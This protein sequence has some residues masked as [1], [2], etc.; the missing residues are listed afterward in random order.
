MTTLTEA[1]DGHFEVYAHGLVY[2]SVCTSLPDG[3]AT[4]RLNWYHPTGVNPWRIADDQTF[5]GG[6]SNPTQCPDRPD[7][8]HILFSC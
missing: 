6:E 8:R 2:A 4:L 5:A 3:A 7:C 1:G